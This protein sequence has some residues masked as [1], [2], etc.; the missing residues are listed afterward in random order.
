M[1]KKLAHCS[2]FLCLACP[3]CVILAEPIRRSGARREEQSRDSASEHDTSLYRRNKQGRKVSVD[4]QE[5]FVLTKHFSG[6]FLRE[7]A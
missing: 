7:V 2:V 3:A 5:A 6:L 4:H 1:T